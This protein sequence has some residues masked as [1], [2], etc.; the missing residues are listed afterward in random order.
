MVMMVMMTINK[1]VML[2]VMMVAAIVEVEATVIVMAQIR[3]E[4]GQV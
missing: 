4:M 2:M 1:E 3:A